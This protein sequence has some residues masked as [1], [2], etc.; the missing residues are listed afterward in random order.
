MISK[1]PIVTPRVIC[2]GEATHLHI[3]IHVD[4]THIGFK[5]IQGLYIGGSNL[6]EVGF[7]ST[8]TFSFATLLLISYMGGYESNN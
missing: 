7:A 4:F 2:M 5:Y 8:L 6:F 1:F 3:Y